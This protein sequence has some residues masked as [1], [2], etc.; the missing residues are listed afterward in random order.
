[1]WFPALSIRSVRCG[2]E[3]RAGATLQPNSCL[4]SGSAHGHAHTHAPGGVSSLALYERSQVSAPV[5][6]SRSPKPKLSQLSQTRSS[7]AESPRTNRIHTSH[8]LGSHSGGRHCARPSRDGYGVRAVPGGC[9]RRR[10]HAPV[11][12]QPCRHRQVREAGRRD[13]RLCGSSARNAQ[14]RP[15][16]DSARPQGPWAGGGGGNSSFVK[17]TKSV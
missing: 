14:N 5:H 2:V 6:S 10:R 17:A 12:G 11:P 8:T 9:Q 13:R 3:R 4:S 1:M 16:A 7:S 15:F